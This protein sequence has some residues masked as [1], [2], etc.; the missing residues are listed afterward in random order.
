MINLN[1]TERDRAS[2]PN[3]RVSQSLLISTLENF[4]IQVPDADTIDVAAWSQHWHLHSF[5]LGDSIDNI[6]ISP[7][8]TVHSELNQKSLIYL[9][10]EGR[11]RLL[12][13]DKNLNREISVSVIEP[14]ET[15]GGD[16]VGWEY[17]SLPYEAIATSDVIVA[18]IPAVEI[19]AQ[20]KLQTYLQTAIENRQRLLFFKTQT[21]LQ[22]LT[23]HRLQELLSGCTQHQIKAGTPLQ[24]AFPTPQSRFWLYQGQIAGTD[25]VP[26]VGDSWGEPDPI[27]PEW[28][29][30]TELVVYQLPTETLQLTSV[31]G[32][33]SPMRKQQTTVTVSPQPATVKLSPVIVPST[34]QTLSFPKP[35]RQRVWRGF[36]QRYPFIQQQSSSDCGVACLAMISQYWGK[37]LSINSLRNISDVGR[38][39]VSLKNLTLTSERLGYQARP[40]R[41]SLNRLET[42]KNPWIAHWQGD[43]YIVVYKVRRDQVVIA[44][45]AEGKKTLS[46]PAFLTGWTGYALLLEP[47]DQFQELQEQKRSLGRF[48]GVIWPHRFLGLQIV[49]LSLL[50]QIFG[51]V[52]PLLTQIILDRVVVNK[53]L[54]GLNVFALG[55]LL[56]GVWSLGLSSIRQYLLSYL[57]NRLDLTLI[58]GFINHALQLPL[59]FFE[60]RRVGDILTRVQEN[61][62]IQRF[63][64]GQILLSALNVVTGFVYLGLMLYYN[65]KLTILI[66]GIVPL[67]IILTLAATPI[68]RQISRQLFNAAADQSS[69]LVE[70]FTGI[71]TVKAVAAEPELRWRWE[72]KLTQ[73]MNV[74]F[75]AQK[76]GIN[77]G[78]VSGLINSIGSTFLLW[79]GVNLVI[80]DQ[81]TIGQFVAFNMMQGYVISPILALVGLWDELQEVL[82]SVERLNDV[83]EQEPEET[84]QKPLIVLPRIQGEI[85]FDNVT[86]RYQEDAETNILQNLSFKFPPGKTIAIV[87][88]SGSG[89]STLVKLMQGLY[90]PTTGHIYVDGH[91]IRHVSP[92]SLRTQMGVVPQDCYLFSGTLLEN[93]TLYRDEYTLDQVIEAAKLAEVHGF[94]QG[95]PLGYYTKV[96]ERGSSLSGGQRQ[97]VAIARA[98]LGSPRILILDEAT[99]SLDTE[100]ESRFQRN[101]EQMQRDRTTIIIAHRLSTVRS[102]D[103]ILVLDKGILVEQGNHEQLMATQGLYYHLAQ[104]QLAL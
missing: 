70:I 71:N 10:V 11:V 2:T 27:P 14:G 65:L 56:F 66:L 86:F 32:G 23:S 6:A 29:A 21:D 13:W 60:S 83:F 45:P 8:K 38:S 4:L 91:E 46:R 44:D 62:K 42:E 69:T 57:S 80:Q 36:W 55:L 93:I 53:S 95:L 94:I 37:Y 101:L 77:L 20:I 33:K 19:I 88:R 96:G 52:T 97:R 102:A 72:E 16:Q 58:G 87:G 90:H 47:T 3:P 67:I 82:I 26:R 48:A 99:S 9:V 49:L 22:R 40:V 98:L 63:L 18:S 1:L 5:Q 59:K 100:S 103:C 64:V 76:L 73:Q 54:T 24:S 7:Q 68:L 35:K 61:Q 89:K 17:S 50:I 34:P 84:P 12:A 25:T 28:I 78:F 43:H 104:Q 15:F 51:I 92:P 41:A 30:T 85:N 81:L 39:G 79:F 75:K 31:Q 74:Q